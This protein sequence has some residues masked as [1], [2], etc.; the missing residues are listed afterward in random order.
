MSHMMPVDIAMRFCLAGSPPLGSFLLEHCSP[1]RP[2]L[3][4]GLHGDACTNTTVTRRSAVCLKKKRNVVFADSQGLALANVHVYNEDE[5]QLLMENQDL[6]LRDR[7]A[8]GSPA[9]VLDFTPPAADYLDLRNRLKAQQV[10]LE[11]CSLQER[12][13]SGTVQVQNL[14]FQK[15]VWVRITFDCWRCF[16]D[17]PC[18][19]LN[20]VYGSPDTNTF[21]FC[22]CIPEVLQ[23]EDRVEFCVQ[24]QTPEGTFWDNNQGNNYR[25]VDPSPGENQETE[26]PGLQIQNQKQRYQ[27]DPFGSPRTSAGVFL[28]QSC[29][30]VETSAPYWARGPTENPLRT[31]EEPTADPRS[32][33]RHFSTSTSAH[34]NLTR[35]IWFSQEPTAHQNLTRLIWFSQEPT[36]HQN[37]TRL[38]WFSQEPT[39]HQNLTRL[40]WFSKEPAAHQNLTRIIWFSSPGCKQGV[41]SPPESSRPPPGTSRGSRVL[42]SPPDL[43]QGQAGGPE[44]SRVLQ[45]FTWGQPGVQRPPDLYQGPAGGPE[46]SRPSP[47]TSRGSRDLQ[48]FT[49]DQQGVQRGPESSRPSPGTSRGSRVLQRPPDL[50]QGPA[51]GP[52]SS[53]PSLGTSRGSRVL[54]TFTRDEQGV[55]SPPDLHQGPA[56]GPESSRDLQ[57]F[58]RDQQGSRVLQTFTRDEQ[59]SRVLQTFTRDEQGSRDLQTFTRDQKGVQRP[60]SGLYLRPKTREAFKA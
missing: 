30:S 13:L 19:Y 59:G 17:V 33:T 28:W 4:S 45:T 37:L 8:D 47:G 58:T 40:I 56:G 2:C 53:R 16:Q 50:H 55:Q 44:S 11:T 5:D 1:L 51:G 20:Q 25:L 42:Q 9:L 48:T 34:Q 39:A 43:H 10:V 26:N 52:E 6:K 27:I 21:S 49:R 24:Y 29:G 57:T 22:V 41:Q 12:L 3:S 54:Q 15:N 31:T 23:P 18:S 32:T 38:I 36:A 7:T 14:C 60:Q 46:T 35:L